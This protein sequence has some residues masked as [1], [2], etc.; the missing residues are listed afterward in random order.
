MEIEEF[1]LKVL[2][3]LGKYEQM[4][5]KAEIPLEIT[6]I[7]LH[8]THCNESGMLMRVLGSKF[9]V[10]NLAL[11]EDEVQFIVQVKK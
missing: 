5:E 3:D 7:Q 6:G 2:K 11:E 1:I 8:P 10:P 9:A 4:L